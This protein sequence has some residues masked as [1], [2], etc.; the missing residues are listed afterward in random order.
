M[1]YEVHSIT[2]PEDPVAYFEYWED[3]KRFAASTSGMVHGVYHIT[4]KGLLIS[5]YDSG[6]EQKVDPGGGL[7]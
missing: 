2:S 1:K 6:I 4:H 5:K 3:A 7:I